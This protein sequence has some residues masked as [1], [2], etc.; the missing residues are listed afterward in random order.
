MEIAH[1]GWF[2]AIARICACR[3]PD[4]SAIACIDAWLDASAGSFGNIGKVTLEPV[5]RLFESQPRH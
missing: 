4:P 5:E 3:P 1:Q 2:V